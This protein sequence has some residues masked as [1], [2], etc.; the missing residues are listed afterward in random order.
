MRPK[1]ARA[2]LLAAP[3]FLAACTA[4]APVE[5]QQAAAE[6]EPVRPNCRVPEGERESPTNDAGYFPPALLE[7]GVACGFRNACT[8]LLSGFKMDWFAEHLIAAGEP[9]LHRA[10]QQPRAADARTIR[11]TWLPSFHNPVTVRI[12]SAGATHRL[13]A[14][15]L[16][17]AGGYEP[18]TVQARIERTL[19]PAESERLL[20]AIERTRL[21][22][23]PANPCSLGCDGAQWIFEGI[24]GEGYHFTNFWSP[25]DGPGREVGAMLL[26]LTGWEFEAVY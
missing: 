5:E 23:L 20:A 19:T 15:R 18:G 9:S 11:F 26:D 25:E 3:L 1:A 13:I 8:P 22:A 14:R 21:F 10:A 12:E 16:S 6:R 2:T 24:D 7:S 17:G 4:P